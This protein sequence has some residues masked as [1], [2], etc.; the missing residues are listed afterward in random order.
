MRARK[1]IWNPLTQFNSPKLLSTFIFKSA[2][3]TNVFL[4]K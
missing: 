3:R 1:F 4:S 2:I